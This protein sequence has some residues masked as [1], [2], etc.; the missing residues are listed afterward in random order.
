MIKC[1]NLAQI[2][3]YSGH[4]LDETKL[5]PLLILP[6]RLYITH[7][8]PDQH[9][10]LYAD[11]YKPISDMRSQVYNNSFCEFAVLFLNLLL[12]Y[13]IS[14]LYLTSHWHNGYVSCMSAP[15]CS[16]QMID[17]K[18]PEY[19]SKGQL[20]WGRIH[21][22][23]MLITLEMNETKAWMKVLIYQLSSR[24]TLCSANKPCY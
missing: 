3:G 24:D 8:F 7:R 16:S 10:C 5:W 22:V 14:K 19:M 2:T 9:M 6:K 1:Y 12:G 23:L 11:L 21:L 15:A 17:Q 20:S 13:Y 18:L 4:S